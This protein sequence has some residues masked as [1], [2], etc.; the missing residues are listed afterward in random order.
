MQS[1]QKHKQF[2]KWLNTDLLWWWHLDCM[3]W[4]HQDIGQRGGYEEVM[5]GQ[6]RFWTFRSY[7]KWKLNWDA[8][9]W[10]LACSPAAIPLF[11]ES[12]I[13]WLFVL[14]LW[15]LRLTVRYPANTWNAG[16]MVAKHQVGAK[17]RNICFL[18]KTWHWKSNSEYKKALGRNE[19]LFLFDTSVLDDSRQIT[20]SPCLILTSVKQGWPQ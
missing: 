8:S 10:H 6:I 19:M 17:R 5:F 16:A 3:V 14:G 13:C 9:K 18:C 12:W 2:R 20:M 4:Q 7:N 1:L 15:E 11:S